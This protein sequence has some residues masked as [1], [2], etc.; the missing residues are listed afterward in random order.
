MTPVLGCAAGKSPW[1]V[2]LFPL[3]DWLV[4][5]GSFENSKVEES[6]ALL[7]LLE[8]FWFP[9]LL[10]SSRLKTEKLIPALGLGLGNTEAENGL[11]E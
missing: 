8:R 11:F 3:P 1:F 10:S 6:V 5:N 7:L 2:T 9:E 4:A